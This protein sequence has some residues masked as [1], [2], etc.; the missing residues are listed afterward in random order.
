MVAHHLEVERKFEMLDLTQATPELTWSFDGFTADHPVVENLDATYYDTASQALGRHQVALRRRTGGYDQGWHIKFD[1]AGGRHE[2]TFELEEGDKIPA[3]VADFLA[4]VLLEEQAVPAVSLL[5]RRVRTVVRS[6]AGAAIAE[7]CDDSVAAT[8]FSTG[9]ERTWHEWE[10]ELLDGGLEDP[11]G[12]ARV[13]AAVEATLLAAG[14]SASTSTAKIARAL[15]ADAEF[16]ARRAQQLGAAA[17]VP[18]GLFPAPADDKVILPS[19]HLLAGIVRDLTVKLAQADLL[20]RAGAPDSTHQGRVAAR[21][22]RS[23]IKYMAQPYAQEAEAK[24]SLKQLAKGLKTYARQLEPHRNGELIAELV[25]ETVESSP[26]TVAL[27]SQTLKQVLEAEDA[28]YLKNAR[29]YITSPA[30]LDLQAGLI[31]LA[32]DVTA[33]CDLPLNP[34]N[35]INKVSKR[36]RKH[37]VKTAAP[38]AATYPQDPQG[39]AASAHLDE[40]VH[41]VR[42]L[43]KAARYC[44][45]AIK[46]A[47][48]QLTSGQQEL[49]NLA[50]KIQSQQGKLTDQNTL[51]AW[52]L[53][54]QGAVDQLTLGYLLGRSDLKA[55]VV[56]ITLG[57]SITCQLETLKDMQ[58]K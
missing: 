44:L 48:G 34:D 2:V 39:R 30:R 37:L 8:D 3:A 38:L 33:Y 17:Q 56:R 14:A 22:L 27:Q 46:A 42:K 31:Q 15:G 1:A 21:Q 18:G 26:A 12:A 57:A 25:T 40:Q 9:V 58:L 24:T 32:T 11:D 45:S 5:T 50:K 41:D 10:V 28:T 51:A 20:I 53:G 55:E 47:G 29:T 49:L 43:A 16:E 23:V 4:P 54:H 19:A 13:F 6:E 7:I 35:Y 36:L 52:L